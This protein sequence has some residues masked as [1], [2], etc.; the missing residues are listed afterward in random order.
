[1]RQDHTADEIDIGV[2]AEDFIDLLD[3]IA[4]NQAIVVGKSQDFTP[5]FSDPEIERKRFPLSRLEK[6]TKPS[7]K[8]RDVRLDGF[9]RV[10]FGIIIH[11]QNLKRPFLRRLLR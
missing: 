9:L 11:Y 6:I 5:G 1:M 8:L 2:V 4:G 3:I 10:I 7:L